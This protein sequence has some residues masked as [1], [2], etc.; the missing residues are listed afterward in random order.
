VGEQPKV[1][2]EHLGHSTTSV[3]MDTYSHVLPDMQRKAASKLDA[4]FAAE[5]G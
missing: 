4:L 1:V 2:Q 3:T 5:A